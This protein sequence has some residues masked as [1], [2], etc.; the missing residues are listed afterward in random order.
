MRQIRKTPLIFL[1]GV[2]LFIFSHFLFKSALRSVEPV[3]AWNEKTIMVIRAKKETLFWPG[4]NEVLTTIDPEWPSAIAK[5]K[6][7]TGYSPLELAQKLFPEPFELIISQN[8]NQDSDKTGLRYNFILVT[9]ASGKGVENLEASHSAAKDFVSWFKPTKHY[10][11]APDGSKIKSHIA[12]PLKISLRQEVFM[13]VEIKYISE[14]G[15]PFE[16]AYAQN[17]GWLYLATSKSALEQL[18]SRDD[19]TLAFKVFRRNCASP[20]PAVSVFFNPKIFRIESNPN[21][22]IISSPIKNILT[23][24]TA[25][26][27]RISS[28]GISLS[29]DRCAF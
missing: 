16:Y 3:S 18:I 25:N 29:W 28:D 19:Q 6:N 2:L 8:S 15:L 27:M 20:G 26:T 4:V 11:I 17:N 21:L 10:T 13:G 23:A 9:K 5:I 14:L 7:K 1:T 12:D 22:L 24:M